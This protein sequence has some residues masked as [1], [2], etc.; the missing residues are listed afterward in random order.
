MDLNKTYLEK[1][2]LPTEHLVAEVSDGEDEDEAELLCCK[3]HGLLRT[4]V[5]YRYT[6]R[7][8]CYIRMSDTHLQY[9]LLVSRRAAEGGCRRRHCG[10]WCR[11]GCDSF[12]F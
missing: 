1:P 12:S 10:R 9:L 5:R 8:T 11:S 3:V 4:Q 6:C 7:G 2:I